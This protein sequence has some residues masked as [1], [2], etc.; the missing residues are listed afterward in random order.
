MFVYVG[1]WC[2]CATW[3]GVFRWFVYLMPGAVNCGL[4]VV[5]LCAKLV[6]AILLVCVGVSVVC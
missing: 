4:G 1:L 6:F 2:L 3:V 5:L